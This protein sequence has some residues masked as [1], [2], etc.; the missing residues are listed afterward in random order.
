LHTPDELAALSEPGAAEESAAEESAAQERPAQEPAVGEPAP[1][2]WQTLDSHSEQVRDQAAA[3]LA[4]LAPQ[5]PAAARAS[6]VVAG[7]LHDA[8]KGH[9]TW[10]DAL[11]A[12]APDEDRESVLAGRPWAKSGHGA[13]GRLEFAGGV[14]FLHELASLLLAEG[15]LRG[16][17]AAAPDP[18]LCRYLIL[19]HHGR[20]RTRVADPGSPQPGEAF[21]LAHGMV[22]DVPPMLGQQGATLA[23]DLRQFTGAAGGSPWSQATRALLERMGPFR[24]AYLE[25]IVRIADWRASGGRELAG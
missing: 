9:P 25:A 13:A 5:V 17:L 8:G 18:D 19:A 20:L 10:Q 16:L 7:Y 3:L 24:I 23:V 21:G 22:S 15:P 14:S 12:L 4:V 2:P 6:A 11:C 1:R